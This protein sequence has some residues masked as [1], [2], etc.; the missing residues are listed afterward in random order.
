MEQRSIAEAMA[1]RGLPMLYVET[2]YSPDD[3]GQ[4]STRV[5]A[6]IESIKGRKRRRG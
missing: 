2:D 3:L 4:L 6:F 1:E 5:E